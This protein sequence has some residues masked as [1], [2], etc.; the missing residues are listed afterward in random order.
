MSQNEINI[1]VTERVPQ[2]KGSN[3]RLRSMGKIPCILYGHGIEPVPLT[4]D[5]KQIIPVI[6]HP[7]I[8]TL[9]FEEGKESRKALIKEVQHNYLHSTVTHVDFQ[10]VI[11][12]EAITAEV[13]L[14]VVGHPIGAQHGGQLD[15]ITHS[16]E[17]ECLP[18]DLPD[19]ITFDVS[20]L[21]VGDNVSIGDISLPKG[22]KAIHIDP[23]TTVIHVIR[24]R[25]AE[26]A[27]EE[28]EGKAEATSEEPEVITKRK[29]EEEEK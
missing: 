19:R 20:H 18:N 26:E 13:P 25:L 8:L 10:Q 3:K 4:V 17:V 1:T 22:V 24:P 27:V 14:E 6:N 7:S 5:L 29:K 11:M 28:T 21:D 2:G 15:Q 16:I 9:N 23:H 12:D